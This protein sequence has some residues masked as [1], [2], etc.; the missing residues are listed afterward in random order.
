MVLF[1]LTLTPS[2]AA[3]NSRPVL[4]VGQA[5]EF[6]ILFNVIDED[7]IRVTLVPELLPRNMFEANSESLLLKKNFCAMESIGRDAA[8]P[9]IY[10]RIVAKC[11]N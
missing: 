7:Q 11:Q 6:S 10:P 1:L 9:C 2:A 4:T 3:Q 5:E 8:T